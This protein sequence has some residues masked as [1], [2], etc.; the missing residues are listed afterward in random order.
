MSLCMET[1]KELLTL[2]RTYFCAPALVPAAATT[3]P[4]VCR[5][6][7]DGACASHESRSSATWPRNETRYEERNVRRASAREGESG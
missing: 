6:A 1:R 3:C 5:T 7:D 2:I 4:A